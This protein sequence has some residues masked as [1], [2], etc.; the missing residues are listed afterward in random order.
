MGKDKPGKKDARTL[1]KEKHLVLPVVPE[2]IEAKAKLGRGEIETPKEI[3]EIDALIFSRGRLN[4]QFFRG[5]R[6]LY[7]VPSW[8]ERMLNPESR[9]VLSLGHCSSFIN[10]NYRNWTAFGGVDCFSEGIVTDRGLV[11]PLNNGYG[12][13]SGFF[14]GKQ[15][16]FPSRDGEVT[17]TLAEKIL[18]IIITKWEVQG[19]R[20]KQVVFGSKQ[21]ENEVGTILLTKEPKTAGQLLLSLRP[22]NQEGVFLIHSLRY[23]AKSQT[24]IINK[25]YYLQ[26]K[27]KPEKIFI[28]NYHFLGD[29]ATR[30]GDKLNGGTTGTIEVAVQCSV[31]LAN[32]TFLF[33]E[34]EQQVELQFSMTKGPFKATT[35]NQEAITALWKTKVNSGL[36]IKTGN[37]EMDRLFY[38]SLANL[39]LLVDPGTITPGPT[40]Y[41]HFW[42]RDAAFLINAL[43]KTGFHS[44]A[45]EILQQFISRQ[46]ANGFY[47]SHEGEYDSPGEGIWAFTQ[48]YKLTRD[49]TW[50]EGVFP[51]LEKAA[52]WIIR[53]RKQNKQDLIPEK[54]RQLVQGLL[55]PGY[56]AEHL[57]P[58]DYFYWDNFWGVAGVRDAAYCAKILNHGIATELQKE[59]QAYLFDLLSSTTKVFQKYGFL[60]VGPLRKGDSAMIANLVAFHPTAIWDGRNMILR[61]TAEEL[62]R[63]HTIKGGFFH[64]VAWNCYGTYLTMHL[65][66]IFHELN[67]SKRLRE[68]L[69][70]LLKYQTSPMGWAEGI[71]PQ[72]MAGGMGDSPHGWAS[73]DWLLLLR[74]MF[75]SETLDGSL[76]LLSGFPPENLRKG[77]EIKGLRTF[78]GTIDFKARLSKKKLSVKLLQDLAIPSLKLVTPSLVAKIITDKG[79]AFKVDEQ[80]VEISTKAKK[81]TIEFE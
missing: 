37:N 45:R 19:K 3:E 47:Y 42:C 49:K 4:A 57:G 36:K 75:C 44:Y 59:Y 22:F 12:I 54:N 79:D 14:D 28:G 62:Y 32:M 76:K 33:P 7:V 21:A 38:A 25:D 20:F 23:N 53:T 17:Q 27:Q 77:I 13:L 40:E 31:G 5:N 48:H 72:T 15:T 9:G 67:D 60:P 68:V 10:T 2:M 18:P 35:L 29:S 6:T 70:W 8:V 56:S 58:C 64:D 65:A 34:Q 16:Y 50:L 80:A 46:R 61:E 26:L 24:I 43:D 55:P 39:L 74:N 81:V 69:K 78:Y 71:S 51:S 66:Q 30:V 1:I 11:V 63:H 73:A 41:H 52:Q